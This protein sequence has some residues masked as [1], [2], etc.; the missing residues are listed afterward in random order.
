MEL[1][2]YD[3]KKK[4][5]EWG[6]SQAMWSARYFNG[7]LYALGRLQFEIGYYHL[8]ALKGLLAP[9]DPVLFIHIPARGK[10]DDEACGQSF[11]SA[12][13]FFPRHFPEHKFKAFVCQSWMLSRQL[14]QLLPADSNLVR[15][16]RRFRPVE[17]PD[18]TD[19]QMW[20]RVFGRYYEQLSDAPSD[21][22]LQRVILRYIGGGGQWQ[23]GAGYILREEID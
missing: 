11:R 18:A 5:A 19:R 2:L 3:Y 23:D 1:W 4:H 17:R 8:P 20:E 22:A 9:G 6:Y 14:E 13:E 16:F 12:A 15:F 21:T 7:E 10:L